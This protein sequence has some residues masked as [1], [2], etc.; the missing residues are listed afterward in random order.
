MPGEEVLAEV[1][2]LFPELPVIGVTADKEVRSA[3]RCMKLGAF[4][5]LVKPVNGDELVAAAERALEH[6]AL[7]YENIR[8]REQF[9]AEKL[10]NPAAFAEIIT[11]E[12]A[13]LRLFGYLEAIAH[14]SHPVLITGETGTG[15]E[16][17]ARALHRVSRRGGAF[18]AV[19]A[20]GLDDTMFSDTLFGHRAGAFT[21]AASQRRGMI[22]KAGE[23]T[24][25]LDEIGELTETSQ[26]KLLRLLQEREYF[27]LGSDSP[28]PLR[29]RVVAATNK[30]P[31]ALRPDLYYRLRSYQVRIPPLRERPNDLP[32][33]VD[34]FL[35]AAAADL[36]KPKLKVPPALFQHLARY[37]FPGNVRELQGMIFDA[38]A[39]TNGDGLPLEPFPEIGGAEESAAVEAA[40]PSGSSPGDTLFGLLREGA[41]EFQER[42]IIREEEWEELKRENVLAALRRTD[43]RVAG[44]G[45]AAELLGLRPTTLRSR[46]KSLGIEKPR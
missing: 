11:V 15:K 26:V 12:P 25:L 9:F 45:G 30:D 27:Q 3:V 38:A 44:R 14:G 5:Y 16:L 19:N 28:R 20:A 36:G 34:Y 10:Q 43:W 40:T 23:G 8:L 41:R 32:L 1:S 18:M 4:D 33:L 21:G 35:A 2:R 24:L 7:R 42:P 6:G 17:V 39:R 31:C 37:R 22:E 46:M 29:A 13:M